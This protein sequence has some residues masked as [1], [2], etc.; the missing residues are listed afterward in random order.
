[1]I[2]SLPIVLVSALLIAA[3]GCGGHTA[4]QAYTVDQALDLMGHPNHQQCVVDHDFNDGLAIYM[5]GSIQCDA[6]AD[7]RD[8][9]YFSCDHQNMGEMGWQKCVRDRGGEMT[10]LTREQCQQ[11]FWMPGVWGSPDDDY[12]NDDNRK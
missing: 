7:Y 5:C 1:M 11:R 3:T 2:R 12:P 9:D 10:Q 4:V 8:D 6:M